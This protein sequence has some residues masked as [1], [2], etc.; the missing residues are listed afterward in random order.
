MITQGTRPHK[1]RVPV[2][3]EE[4]THQTNK[5]VHA[6]QSPH[7][8]RIRRKAHRQ[9]KDDNVTTKTTQAHRP[10][11]KCERNIFT[12]GQHKGNI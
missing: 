3:Y 4:Q 9:T 7:P 8:H 11:S 5:Q 12:A 1:P 10:S 6:S 2:T